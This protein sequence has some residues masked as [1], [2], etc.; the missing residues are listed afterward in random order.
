VSDTRA[1]RGSEWD[2]VVEV[3]HRFANVM[4]SRAHYPAGHPA[5]E[6]AV[7]AAADGLGRVLGHIPELV[8]TLADGEFVICDRPMPE[9]R[10][11]L[12]GLAE[13]MERHEIECM[14]FMRGLLAS[15]VEILGTALGKAGDAPGR[16]R[17]LAQTHLI[18]ILLRF[19][20]VHTHDKDRLGEVHA[21][22]LL[23]AVQQVLDHV[24]HA[25]A[26]E[27]LVDVAA[28]RQLAERIA[29]ACQHR[30][31][32]LLT[33]CYVP[34]FDDQAAHATNVAMMTS[35]LA[36]AGRVPD[37]LVVDVTA[38]AMLH[39]VGTLLAPGATRG[40]PEPVLDEDHRAVFRHHPVAGGWA[41]LT[42]GCPPLWVSVA[43]EHHRGIDGR[44]YPTLTRGDGPHELVRTV[45]LASFFDRK[46]TLLDGRIDDPD[47]ALRQASRL[48][49]AYFGPP[50]VT[51]FVRTFGVFP[52]GTI[53]ELSDRQGALVTHASAHDPMRP[54]VKLLT[55][56]RAGRRVDLGRRNL[57]EERH[58]LSIVRAILP[59]LALFE[60]HEAEAGQGPEPAPPPA[61]ESLGTAA[62]AAPDHAAVATSAPES[63][64]AYL[65]RLGGLE[66]IPELIR[67]DLG[68]A[69][70]DHR[71]GFLLTFVDGAAPLELLLDMTG[72][73][74]LDVLR[75]VAG[76]VEAGVLRMR[77]A[78]G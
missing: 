57:V 27:Q 9:L 58:E 70:L 44:G 39:D 7:L 12:G 20:E 42:T 43:L 69:S 34:G 62:V 15:E 33:R 28:I 3:L 64:A 46:R 18:H 26:N 72:L 77:P 71:A 4:T 29:S 36:I 65:D 40:L 11:N 19:A 47:E 22:A 6:R 14:V 76:L 31:Y 56:P 49:K 50:L 51:R 68:A 38:A 35:A 75:V 52:P 10:D 23:P 73:P 61:E 60:P 78:A 1:P 21:A 63:E 54:H 5:I 25:F 16:V 74:R 13:A 67:S 55:G 37:S 53:V 41:L 32:T 2:D 30:A 17:E 66:A 48:E 59:P 8:I 45:S 24:L